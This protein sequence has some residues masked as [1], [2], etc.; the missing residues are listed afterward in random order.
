MAGKSWKQV[1]QDRMDPDWADEIDLFESQIELRKQGKLEEKVFAETR[2]RRGAYGQRYDNGQRHDGIAERTLALRRRARPRAPRR[3]WDAPGMQRIKIPFGGVSP[4]QLEVLAELA[5]EYSDAILHVTTRQDIQLHF[6]HIEDTP[7]LMRRLAAV[8]ITTREA[9]GN[10]VRNVTACPLAGVCR[11]E[12]FDVS[13]YAQ[14]ADALPARPSRRAG[15]RPQVQARVLRL[16][17]RG[18]RPGQDARRRLRREASWTASAASR[19][20][21]AAGSAR[22]RTRPRCSPSSRP[23]RSCCP[24]TQAVARVFARLGEKQNRGRARIKF[25]V[26]KLG[27]EEFRRLV[28][29]GA[30]ASC[31]TTRAGP[32]I[33]SDMP[34]THGEPAARRARARARARGPPGFDAW[35]ATNVTPQRQPGYAV[36]TLDA[37]ARR[38]HLRPDAARSP[39]SRASTPATTCAP[40]SSRTSA[41]ASSPRPT[42]RRSTRSCARPGSRRPAPARSSTSR[43]APAPTPASSASPSSRGL[44][45]GAARGGSRRE[46]GVAADG[47]EGPAD[48]DH[49]LLQQLRPAPRRRHRLLRQQPQG[50]RPHRAA[51][52]GDPRRAVDRERRHLRAGGRLGAEQGDPADDR[53][54]DRRLRARAPGRTSASRP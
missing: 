20:S 49:R 33:L 36:A 29:G 5:E 22:C 8:G 52:P 13:P 34:H 28:G 53:R 19:S 51:L 44:G 11:T 39:T 32:P 23:R 2:L 3:V 26:A 7:D 37:A 42:C 24:Q 18:L 45:R 54:A 16:R 46:V 12:A 27:I 40:P 17:A 47:G 25:L 38:P 14:G 21:S 35:R 6:V 43:R 41:S 31:P 50:R 1:L 4:E 10:S 15:L 30:H 9:C 48:Q